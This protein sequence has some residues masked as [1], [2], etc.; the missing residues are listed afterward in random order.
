MIYETLRV[1]IQNKDFTLNEILGTIDM[2]YASGKLTL[3]QHTELMSMARENA[4]PIMES[5]VNDKILELAEKMHE[6][7]QRV[8]ALESGSE[9]SG[10]TEESTVKPYIPGKW[11]Y[12]GD[13]ALWKDEVYL[14]VAPDGVV[15]VWDPDTYPVYWQ[16]LL[17]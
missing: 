11:Y 16:K 9:D 4:D 15:C 12:N 8:L 13:K 1:R 5:G 2:F 3:E 7:E 17:A 14:C 6:L 10:S